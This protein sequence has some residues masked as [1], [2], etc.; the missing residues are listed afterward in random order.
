MAMYEQG[1]L[2]L[3]LYDKLRSKYKG[4]SSTLFPLIYI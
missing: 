3:A 4:L 1:G 2:S